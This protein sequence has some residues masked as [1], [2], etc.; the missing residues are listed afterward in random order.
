MLLRVEHGDLRRRAGF[1]HDEIG[2]RLSARR[3]RHQEAAEIVGL[4]HGRREPDRGELRRQREQPR[5]TKR[6]QVAAFG[7]GERV[8]FIEHHALERGEQIWRVGR[9]EQQR[10]LLRRGQQDVGR[11]AALSLPLGGGRVAGA[12]LQAHGEAHL[13]HRDFQVAGDIDGQ[14]LQRRDVEG[15]QAGRL[16][17]PHA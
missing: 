16:P 12:G 1:G 14:R 17:S 11:I 5:E 10:Q 13:A 4:G 2:A 3:L 6:E 7:G 15:V 8:Q 9:G